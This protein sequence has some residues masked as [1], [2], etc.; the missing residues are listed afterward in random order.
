[1]GLDELGIFSGI[2]DLPVMP[3][4]VMSRD[5]PPHNLS[6]EAMVLDDPDYELMLMWT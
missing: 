6:F 1:M 2:E 4:F 3:I 5:P